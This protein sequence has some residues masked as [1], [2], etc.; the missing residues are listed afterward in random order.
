SGKDISRTRF[1]SISVFSENLA[2]VVLGVSPSRDPEWDSIN[3]SAWAIVDCHQREIWFIAL[4]V[5]IDIR[6]CFALPRDIW[7]DGFGCSAEL[8]P[9]RDAARIVIG[10]LPVG[11]QKDTAASQC[12]LPGICPSLVGNRQTGLLTNQLDVVDRERIIRKNHSSMK[13]AP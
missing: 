2:S 10:Q 13:F 8:R 5:F 4:F 7:G 1:S 3:L 11:L 9:V 12:F 6:E